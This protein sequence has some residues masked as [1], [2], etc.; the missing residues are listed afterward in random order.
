ML[1]VIKIQTFHGFL[2][3]TNVS[4]FTVFFHVFPK[5]YSKRTRH[6]YT[7]SIFEW[8]QKLPVN[9]API[10]WPP[11]NHRFMESQNLQNHRLICPTRK[12]KRYVLDFLDYLLSTRIRKCHCINN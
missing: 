3:T 11:E 7:Q 2:G 1:K 4:Q 12:Q 5:Y 6:L 8:D 10:F 9:V